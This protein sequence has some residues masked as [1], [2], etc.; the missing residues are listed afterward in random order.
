MGAEVAKWRQRQIIFVVYVIF[1][2][3]CTS[4]TILTRP[5]RTVASAAALSRISSSVINLVQ[6]NCTK[7]HDAMQIL[8]DERQLL[9]IS[10][11][12]VVAAVI[13]E[14]DLWIVMRRRTPQNNNIQVN[15]FNWSS[16]RD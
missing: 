15:A 1:K 11:R 9:I 5:P 3:T 8:S 14:T 6:H 4:F 12:Y 16:W 10:M 2:R 13:N 7:N